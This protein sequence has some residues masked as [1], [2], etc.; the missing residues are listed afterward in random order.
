MN[1]VKTFHFLFD[2][3][4]YHRS[5]ALPDMGLEDLDLFERVKRCVKEIKATG[6]SSIVERREFRFAPLEQ[7]VIHYALGFDQVEITSLNARYLL[8]VIKIVDQVVKKLSIITGQTSYPLRQEILRLSSPAMSSC[9]AYTLTSDRQQMGQLEYLCRPVNWVAEEVGHQA[10]AIAALFIEMA[11]VPVTAPIF[12]AIRGNTCS[13]KSAYLQQLFQ[14]DK[15]F[16]SLDPIKAFLKRNARLTNVQVYEEAN[17]LFAGFLNGV[18]KQK[19]LRFI[20]DSRLLAVEYIQK[21]VIMRAE[22]RCE[23]VRFVDLD[24]PLYT[25]LTRTFARDPFGS[26][27]CVPA[28]AVVFGF[29]QIRKERAALIDLVRENPNV[30]S[31]KLYYDGKLVAEKIDGAFRIYSQERYLECLRV[32][33]QKEIDVVLAR[34]GIKEALDAKAFQTERLV[35]AIPADRAKF[36]IPSAEVLMA[37]YMDFYKRMGIKYISRDLPG[38]KISPD[39]YSLYVEQLPNWFMCNAVFVAVPL[40]LRD[41]ES[42]QNISISFRIDMYSAPYGLVDL[43][44]YAK[45]HETPV[46]FLLDHYDY[47]DFGW[48]SIAAFLGDHVTDYGVM[49]IFERLLK[50][51][52]LA[53]DPL[54][55]ALAYPALKSGAEELLFEYGGLSTLAPHLDEPH[56]RQRFEEISCTSPNKIWRITALNYLDNIDPVFDKLDREICST[57]FLGKDYRYQEFLLWHGRTD[58]DLDSARLCETL[59]KEPDIYL[60]SIVKWI[61]VNTEDAGVLERIAVALAGFPGE[62]IPDFTPVTKLKAQNR[63]FGTEKARSPITGN[64]IETWMRVEGDYNA[65]LEKAIFN[66]ERSKAIRVAALRKCAI[67]MFRGNKPE[68]G[69]VGR[70]AIEK[71]LKDPTDELYEEAKRI[72]AFEF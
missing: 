14:I 19:K 60:Y 30:T 33:D 6:E 55:K 17:A 69:E 10:K 12:Y 21:N 28:D 42:L 46:R 47:W 3:T 58:A 25:S 38:C 16:L 37:K 57:L 26:E 31:Y 49:D 43:V 71:L 50:E 51:E 70:A 27:S 63:H 64:K 48:E 15:G 7:K 1:N 59:Q 8:R 20:F 9:E 72:S 62:K 67:E 23:E 68:R 13:G 5:P 22:Q 32:P 40:I 4:I 39:G 66:P 61:G 52:K 45:N 29:L 11:Q 56:I 2:A 18:F 65:E 53:F 24:V 41:E 35:C 44:T 36:E 34:S 54:S